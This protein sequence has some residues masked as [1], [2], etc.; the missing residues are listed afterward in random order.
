MIENSRNRVLLKMKLLFCSTLLAIL[1]GCALAPQYSGPRSDH[2]NGEEF[3]NTL[4]DDKGL[5]D[6]LSYTLTFPFRKSVWPGRVVRANAADAIV[7]RIDDGLAITLINHSTVLIQVAGT[8]ILTDPIFAERASPFTW[9]GP[10][11]VTEPAIALNN[12]PPI[13]LILVSHNHYDHLDIEAIRHISKADSGERQPLILLGLGNGRLL[14]EEGLQNFLELDWDDSV[15][16]DD[17]QVEFSEARHRSGRGLRDQMKTLWGAFV[18]TTPQGKIYFGGDSGYGPHFADTR[19]KHGDFQVALLPI[20]AYEP[21]S[22]MAPV[23]LNPEEAV[24]AHL[25]LSSHLSIAIHHSTFQLTYEGI[26]APRE[27]LN[28][29]LDENGL[30]DED[31]QVLAFGKRINI[32]VTISPPNK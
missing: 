21:R 22:F 5:L 8:N 27:A 20:G 3:E 17:L 7:E 9:A 13:D 15:A 4:K 6:I 19:Q 16:F 18:I 24:K 12:L 11:R 1:F 26:N 30:S 32:P 31:F 29:A 23:H 14:N 2:F 10:K 28:I 25:D